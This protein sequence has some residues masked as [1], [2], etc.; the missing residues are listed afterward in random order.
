MKKSI[1]LSLVCLSAFV[2]TAQTN[3]Q[4]TVSDVT[5]T[6][7]ITINVMVSD[8]TFAELRMYRRVIGETNLSA[9]QLAKTNSAVMIGVLAPTATREINYRKRLLINKIINADDSSFATYEAAL[10]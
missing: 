7:N 3:S 6:N 2:A 4:P 8:Q 9:Q 10:K 5:F 1:L